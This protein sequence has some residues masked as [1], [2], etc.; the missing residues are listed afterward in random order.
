[1]EN[2]F[3]IYRHISPNGKSYIGQTNNIVR[4]NKEHKC[5][6]IKNPV[7]PLF[8]KAVSKYGWDSFKHEVLQ[9]N[10]TLHEANTL[11]EFYIDKFNT[12]VPNGYNLK[13][14]GYNKAYS[15][16]SKDKISKSRKEFYKNNP[17]TIVSE[18]TRKRLSAALMGHAISEETKRRIGDANRGRIMPPDAVRR[19]ADKLRGRKHSEKTKTKIGLAQQGCLNHRFGKTGAKSKSSKTYLIEFPDGETQVVTGLTAFCISHNLT[20]GNMSSVAHGRLKHHK[21]YKCTVFD[22][23]ILAR[24]ETKISVEDALKNGLARR[25][26]K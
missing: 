10:L 25:N 16:E 22:E 24:I 7:C 14:G 4:R 21:Q 5:I 3:C 15:Q 12:I 17:K 8:A 6:G 1:M 23:D 26:L 13:H 20:H 18:E 2:S 19:M 9:S 11:E